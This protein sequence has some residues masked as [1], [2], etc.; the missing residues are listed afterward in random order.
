[1]AYG[2]G[3]FT[4]FDALSG[5]CSLDT[6]TSTARMLV[7]TPGIRWYGATD[8][9]TDDTF[10]A[11][12]NPTYGATPGAELFLVN[13]TSW[14][15]NPLGF[16]AAPPGGGPI[17]EI[18]MD[19]STGTLYGTDYA[20]L[21]TVP[22]APG[23]GTATFVG[24]F[25]T[26]PGTSDLIDYVFS[27]DY[28]PSVGQLV[29]T[30]WRRGADETDL[31]Y[32]D[33]GNGAGTPAG[34]TGVDRF[35]DVWYS[36]D[37]ATLLGASR[38]PGR[39]F[40]ID[41][42]TGAATQIGTTPEVSFY[43]L[44]NA[45]P[46]S[47][48]PLPYTTAGLVDLGYETY[49]FAD[50]ETLVD[51]SGVGLQLASPDPPPDDYGVN[52]AASVDF[53]VPAAVPNQTP[54]QNTS[55]NVTIDLSDAPGVLDGMLRVSSSMTVTAAGSDEGVAGVTRHSS[56]LA[57][58]DIRGAI[59]VGIP[60]GGTAGMPVLFGASVYTWGDGIQPVWDLLITDAGDPQ[61]VYLD[62]DE[63]SDPWTFSFL[64]PAGQVLAYEF[65]L[66]GVLIEAIDGIY[67]LN[68]D[69]DFGA[70]GQVPEPSSAIAVLIGLAAAVRR[71]RGN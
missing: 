13:T 71:R 37:S 63:T 68:A 41:S 61:T 66:D 62:A 1:M 64:V 51:I 7:P 49:A 26:H 39:V 6:A 36:D 12:G 59:G 52:D 31:Y 65:Y 67:T 38:A 60:R 48:E 32:F 42:V 56:V 10:F 57:E 22:T 24:T 28:D 35:T 47:P 9:M 20:N 27:M 50:I 43:G 11:V 44:A 58:G 40:D 53:D 19:E 29:G 45:T 69:V 4:D 54:W 8:G 34:Y 21:Y 70:A 46:G 23:G 16:V 55:G 25:G 17:R 15:V 2:V 14:T 30:S 3:E 33:R 18:G 5:I